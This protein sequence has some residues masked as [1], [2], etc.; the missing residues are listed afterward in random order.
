LNRGAT[1]AELVR[2]RPHADTLARQQDN[3]HTQ[4]QLL[5]AGRLS[6]KRLQ[7]LTLAIGDEDRGR[8]KQG[9]RK[10]PNR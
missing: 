4:S 5:W 1:D 10:N 3:P 6:L 8:T 9:H 7:L 2:R